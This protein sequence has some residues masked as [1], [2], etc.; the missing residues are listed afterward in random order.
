MLFPRDFPIVD[1]VVA[2]SVE[3]EEGRCLQDGVSRWSGR[4]ARRLGLMECYLYGASLREQKEVGCVVDGAQMPGEIRD[5]GGI[6]D[7]GEELASEMEGSA[8]AHGGRSGG[9]A[10]LGDVYGCGMRTVL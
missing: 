6:G 2:A 3:E 7:V 1:G 8:A 5:F 10:W 9:V 4:Y